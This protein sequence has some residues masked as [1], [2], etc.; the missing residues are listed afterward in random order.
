MITDQKEPV[1]T[2]GYV[3]FYRAAVKLDRNVLCKS[4]TRY[5]CDRDVSVRFQFRFDRTDGCLDQMF[6][7]SDLAH[8][9]QRSNQSDRSVSTHSEIADVVKEDHAGRIFLIGRFAKECT[10]H[11]IMPARFA[12]DSSAKIVVITPKAIETFFD[13]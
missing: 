4:I 5:I 11:R 9:F 6:P 1:A 10:Y 7:G 8:M 3:A 12:N 2:P 13:R